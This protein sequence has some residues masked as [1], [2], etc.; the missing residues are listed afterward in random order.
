MGIVAPI[1][2]RLP[3]ASS[4]GVNSSRTKELLSPPAAAVFSQAP[5]FSMERETAQTTD[6]QLPLRDQ[7]AQ[8]P[9]PQTRK[10]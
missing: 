7:T 9:K 5:L 8:T 10:C 1:F 2:L 6:S 4:N 3:R